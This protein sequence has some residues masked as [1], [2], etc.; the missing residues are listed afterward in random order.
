MT[1]LFFLLPTHLPDRHQLWK[2]KLE[3]PAE[4]V[5]Q[6]HQALHTALALVRLPSLNGLLQLRD[7]DPLHRLLL[8]I[9]TIDRLHVPFLTDGGRRVSAKESRFSLRFGNVHSADRYALSRLRKELRHV[10]KLLHDACVE[11][12]LLEVGNVALSLVD[13]RLDLQRVLLPLQAFDERF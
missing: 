7:G 11:G 5:A 6:N 8:R 4:G 3:T 9:A 13:E 2:K 10:V 12:D 1:T